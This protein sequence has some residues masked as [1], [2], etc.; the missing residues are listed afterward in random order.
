MSLWMG[1]AFVSTVVAC[2][3]QALGYSETCTQGDTGSFQVGA[4]LS[5][6]FLIIPIAIFCYFGFMRP[7]PYKWSTKELGCNIGTFCVSFLLLFIN[8]GLAWG[9]LATGATPCYITYD[10]S[11]YSLPQLFSG[12]YNIEDVLVGVVYGVFP[13]ILMTV[14]ALAT[15]KRLSPV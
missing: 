2:V 6:P 12:D 4:M 7:R 10:F 5:A 3:L 13:A 8:R 14:A 15:S 1:A 11:D 9:V